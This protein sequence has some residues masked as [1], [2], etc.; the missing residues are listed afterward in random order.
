M[1]YEESHL[2]YDRLKPFAIGSPVKDCIIEYLFIGPTD[3]EQMTDFMNLRLQKGEEAAQIEFSRQ[4]ISLSV[5]GVSVTR[6]DN[7]VPRWEMIKLDDW[8]LMISN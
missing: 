8:E 1:T 5:Y 7:D 2:L 4:G 3:W 6:L